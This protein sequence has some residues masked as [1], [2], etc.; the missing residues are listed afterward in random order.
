MA[1]PLYP[2]MRARIEMWA[3]LA[4]TSNLRFTVCAMERTIVV[5]VVINIFG[6]WGQDRL[7]ELDCYR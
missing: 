4:G 7:D 3:C 2:K 5:D 6:G 1:I